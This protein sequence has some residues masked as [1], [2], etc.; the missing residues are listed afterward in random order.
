MKIP[1]F[2]KEC[3]K[4]LRQKNKSGLCSN[5]YLVK[6]N[7]KRI[8]YCDGCKGKKYLY[9]YYDEGFQEEFNLC[10]KCLIKSEAEK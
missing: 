10:K 2:C 5:C 6:I 8:G 4:V 7:K 3:K 9:P 1:N